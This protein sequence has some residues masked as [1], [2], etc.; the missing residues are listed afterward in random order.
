VFSCKDFDIRVAVQ[1]ILEYFKPESHKPTIIG[2]R[3]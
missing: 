3:V 2:R 1:T